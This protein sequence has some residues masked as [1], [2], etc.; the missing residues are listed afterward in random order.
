MQANSGVLDTPL[1]NLPIEIWEIILQHLAGSLDPL[2]TVTLASQDISAAAMTCKQLRV[3]ADAAWSRLEQLVCMCPP[4]ND[5]PTNLLSEPWSLTV[6]VL[7]RAAKSLR[8][9]AISTK[10]GLINDIL[11]EFNLTSPSKH[12]IAVLSAVRRDKRITGW[13]TRF[14][15]YNAVIMLNIPWRWNMSRLLRNRNLVDSY[16]TYA[17]LIAAGQ[18]AELELIAAKKRAREQHRAFGRPFGCFRGP[19]CTQKPEAACSKK[20]CR[21]CCNFRLGTCSHHAEMALDKTA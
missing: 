10:F 20:C 1:P 7:R 8:L 21:T 12:P 9:P 19:D 13:Q 14:G 16:G 11:A 6:R 3:A 4:I 18:V 5:L 17:R 2:Y 15:I